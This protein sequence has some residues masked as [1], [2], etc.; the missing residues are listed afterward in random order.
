MKERAPPVSRQDTNA[1]FPLDVR[2]GMEW[3]QTRIALDE[4]RT[5]LEVLERLK[6]GRNEPGYK[7][8]SAFRRRQKL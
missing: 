2:K 5:G 7:K 8:L 3:M 1:L 6:R 4:T